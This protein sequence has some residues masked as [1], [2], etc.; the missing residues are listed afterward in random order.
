MLSYI[1]KGDVMKKALITEIFV[2]LN[3]PPKRL[4]CYIIKKISN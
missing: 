2:L 4:Q 3:L 1:R